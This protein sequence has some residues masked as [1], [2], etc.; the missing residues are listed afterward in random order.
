MAK[1]VLLMISVLVLVL[2]VVGCRKQTEIEAEEGPEAA[3]TAAPVPTERIAPEGEEVQ[4]IN[5]EALFQLQYCNI[6]IA[7]AEWDVTEAEKILKDAEKDL[8]DV[9]EEMVEAREQEDEDELAYL[10]E[11][12]QEEKTTIEQ[13][14]KDIESRQSILAS[15]I[16]DCNIAEKKIT[17]ELCREFIADAEAM[18][19][20][21]QGELARDQEN[22]QQVMDAGQT[23][24]VPKYQ[25]NVAKS[26]VKVQ[27]W[28][29]ALAELQAKC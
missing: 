26:E 10:N 2:F 6:T 20:G 5:Y 14:K 8:A 24:R 11:K 22:L 28:E 3:P 16:N 19:A 17:K 15:K 21:V 29:H 9:E 1:R 27:R 25:R 13:A 18:L 12:K 4:E 23:S 7:D